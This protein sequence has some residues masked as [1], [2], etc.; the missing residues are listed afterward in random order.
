MLSDQSPRC[1]NTGGFFIKTYSS[2]DPCEDEQE[3]NPTILRT[4][5]DDPALHQPDLKDGS[6][7]SGMQELLIKI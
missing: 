7:N 5:A 1:S 6:R 2:G 4:C 3:F